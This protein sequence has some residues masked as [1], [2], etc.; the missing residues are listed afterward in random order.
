MIKRRPGCVRWIIWIVI[1]GGL[2]FVFRYEIEFLRATALY[3]IQGVSGEDFPGLPKAVY[4]L[5]FL[6]LN[7]LAMINFALLMIH[8]TASAVHPIQNIQEAYQLFGRVARSLISKP[9]PILTIRE[10]MPVYKVGNWERSDLAEV[11]LDSAL[12]LEGRRIYPASEQQ[13]RENGAGEAETAGPIMARIGKPGL[14]FIHPGERIREIVSL[15]KQLRMERD[16]LAQTSDGIEVRTNVFCNFALGQPP[17]VIQVAYCGS[18]T[19]ESLS[20]LVIDPQTHMIK[21][22]LDVLDAQEKKEVHQFA[23]DFI[24]CLD[25][26]DTLVLADQT[27]ECPPFTIDER[28][29]EAAVYS[30]ALNVNDGQPYVT[31]TDLP[32]MVAVE[33]FRNMI[34]P[35]SYDSLFLPEEQSRFPLI[36]DIKP[37][38][39]RKLKS[40]GVLSYQFVFRKGNKSPEINQRVDHR[41]FR[42]APPRE[43]QSSKVLRDRGIKVIYAGFSELSPTDQG[44]KLQ[45]F[46]NWQ[47]RWQQEADSSRLD[48]DREVMLTLDKARAR[49]QKEMIDSL[50]NL[51]KSSSYTEEA[52]ILKML[53]AL[54]EAATDP[55]TRQML[56]KETIELLGKLR[57]WMLPERPSTSNLM[58]GQFKQ[59]EE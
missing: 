27:V 44:V 47:V 37:A 20:V 38:F 55:K 28:R 23:K 51:M 57:T 11:D 33:E 31:W 15:R 7:A 17:D 25:P 45:R 41:Q 46:Y 59:A 56:P 12:V 19:P 49:R 26:D 1:L 4:I 39:A 21:N 30:K 18:L 43:F 40:L 52:L 22:I 24:D 32:I 8:W 3:F 53:Q 13:A 36:N 16:V 5:I 29:I 10:A 35:H 34:S 58:E 6:G 2:L 50:S 42:I 14:V 48:L 9:S 54:E